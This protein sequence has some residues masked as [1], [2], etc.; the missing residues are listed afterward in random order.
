M[1]N[2]YLKNLIGITLPNYQIEV[3]ALY[4]DHK[5][6]KIPQGNIDLRFDTIMKELELPRMGKHD[7]INDAVMTAM[8]FLKIININNTV[9]KKYLKN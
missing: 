4:F 5:I 7:A 2:K 8:I 3:S 9:R 6:E 1:V